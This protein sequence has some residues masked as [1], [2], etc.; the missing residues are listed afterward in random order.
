MAY[1]Y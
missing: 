1:H